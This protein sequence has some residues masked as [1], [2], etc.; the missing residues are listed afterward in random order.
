MQDANHPA[1]LQEKSSCPPVL[2]Q[3][4]AVVP[5]EVGGR[6]RWFSDRES[7]QNR[8]SGRG[9]RAASICIDGVRCRRM[10]SAHHD[11]SSFSLVSRIRIIRTTFY[12]TAIRFFLQAVS[13]VKGGPLHKVVKKRKT[14]EKLPRQGLRNPAE[15]LPWEV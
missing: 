5:T 10:V 15:A 11:V 12:S 13:C 1:V 8:N 6:T 9:R 3:L 4:V 2:F 7:E 14:R